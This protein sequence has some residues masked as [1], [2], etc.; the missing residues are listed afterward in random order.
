MVLQ[1]GSSPLHGIVLAGMNH[2]LASLKLLR[3]WIYFGGCE[4]QHVPGQLHLACQACVSCLC[5]MLRS[6]CINLLISSQQQ[7]SI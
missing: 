5:Y 4:P 6:A 1:Q 3:T 2:A 7:V